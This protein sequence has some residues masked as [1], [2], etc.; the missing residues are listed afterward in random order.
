MPRLLDLPHKP[1]GLL[2][3]TVQSLKS[4]DFLDLSVPICI[5]SNVPF[6]LLPPFIDYIFAKGIHLI[7]WL[8]FL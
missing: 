3:G 6:Y 1:H 7:D 8:F 2:I 4:P 5:I